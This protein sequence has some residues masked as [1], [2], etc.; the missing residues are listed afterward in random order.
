[1][2]DGPP[3]I[4]RLT[5]RGR[6]GVRAGLLLV[7]LIGA[8]L[9]LFLPLPA[10]A[11]PL[12]LRLAP[13]RVR[14]GGVTVLSIRSPTALRMLRVQVG[15]REIHSPAPDGRARVALL[16]GIDLEQPPGPVIVRA[17]AE[18]Q[19]GRPLAG[20]REVRVLDAHFPLQRLS[21]P[22]SFVELDAATLERVDREKAVLDHL[23]DVVTPD[24]FWRGPFRLPLDGAGPASGFGVRRIINGEPRTPHSGADFPA[25]A[26]TPVVAANAG[27]VALVADH[28]FAGTSIILDHGLG[29]Y[30]MYFHLQESLVQP[31]QRVDAGQVIARVGSTGRA[32]GPHLHWGARL[33]GAR[34][35]PRALLRSFP[36]Q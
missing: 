25:A 9:H 7:T 8:S 23:W 6:W 4:R 29:L 27:V 33:Y 26:G 1:M 3:A 17:E 36:L 28:F 11:S 20:Q 32:T 30:T 31:G 15:D 13:A 24:P 12:S 16:I 5:T 18:D 35:D 34:I 2:S 22:R 21:V 19:N 10:A 14:Q